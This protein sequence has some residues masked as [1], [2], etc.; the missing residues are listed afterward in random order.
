MAL[1][2]LMLDWNRKLKEYGVK[3]RAEGPGFL[4]TGLGNMRENAVEM[5][6]GHASIGGQILKSVVEGK[7]DAA[8]GKLVVKEVPKPF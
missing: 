1:N 4:A 2:M 7:Y 5:G 8:V 3:L 6:C